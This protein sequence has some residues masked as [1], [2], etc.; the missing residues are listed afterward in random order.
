MFE[1][2]Y[3]PNPAGS[4]LAALVIYSS[5][6]N[7][8][9][10][11]VSYVSPKVSATTAASIRTIARYVADI[12]PPNPPASVTPVIVNG[13]VKLTWSVAD[14]AVTYRVQ[15]AT[16]AGGKY[17]TVASGVTGT[18]FTSSTLTPGKTYYYAISAVNARGESPRSYPVIV[19]R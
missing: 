5:I 9:P 13:R 16:T 2:D 6:F 8:T 1:D 15:R 14:R 11:G 3:H 19:K 18:T 7:A 12:G 17:S 10:I 4:Y